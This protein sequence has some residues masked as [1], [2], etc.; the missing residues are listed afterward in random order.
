MAQA[1]DEILKEIKSLEPFPQAAM[2]VLELSSRDEVVPRDL[3]AVIETDAA[4]TARVLKLSNSAYYGF[5]R[6]IA[7]ISEAGNLLGVSAL[8]NLVL[9]SCAGR[10]F[11]GGNGGVG[12]ELERAWE[13]SVSNALAASLLARLS[14]SVDRNRAYTAGLLQNIGQV[15]LERFLQR[16]E[17]EI[18]RHVANGTP[19]IAA[20]REVLG[21]DHAEVGARLC[22]RW[23]F[24]DVLVDAVRHHHEPE[25]STIDPLLTCFVHLGEQVTLRMMRADERKPRGYELDGGALGI[26]K[27]EL[28]ALD[29]IAEVLAKEVEQAR[30][31]MDAG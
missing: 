9:T 14:G 5:R 11:R 4:M 17:Q 28:E 19:R 21:L 18:S 20:E 1:L 29:G 15:V 25:R 16:E 7:A 2:R 3:I 26:A 22:E 13:Q 31:F 30:E 8:V 10:S 12:Q 24:P 23:N 27:L 6:E